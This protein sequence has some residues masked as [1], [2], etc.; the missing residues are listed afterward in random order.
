MRIDA[1]FAPH[2]EHRNRPGSAWT[3]VRGGTFARSKATCRPQLS[4]NTRMVNCSGGK[5][6]S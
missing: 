5:S 2:T 6:A 1:C 3:L 4:Q